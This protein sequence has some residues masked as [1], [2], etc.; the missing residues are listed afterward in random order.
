MRLSALVLGLTLLASP[1]FAGE[2]MVA[3]CK[4]CL[5]NAIAGAEPGD[6]LLLEDGRHEGAVTIDRT[7]TITGSREAVVDGLGKGTVITIEA[8]GVVLR[9][10]TVTGSGHVNADL[11]AGV[12]IRKGADRALIEG[13]LVEEIGR[14][15]V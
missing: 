10:F 13:L 12:K 3:P 11:D 14:A 4:G 8:E 7:L 6:V 15:H 5:A 1:A 9:G 2:R